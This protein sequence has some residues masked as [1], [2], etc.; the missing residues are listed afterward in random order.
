MAL[1]D[2]PDR[3]EPDV[4]HETPRWDLIGVTTRPELIPLLVLSTVTA[5]VAGWFLFPAEW[6][7]STKLIGGFLLGVGSWLILYTNR[8]IGGQDFN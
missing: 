2:E 8:M 5:L 7:A 6:A 1:P 3:P 4:H